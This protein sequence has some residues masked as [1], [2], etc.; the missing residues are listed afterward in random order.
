MAVAWGGNL[1][2]L[3][4]LMTACPLQL[5]LRCPFAGLRNTYLDSRN[6]FLGVLRG[7]TKILHWNCIFYGKISAKKNNRAI[8][9]G[10]GLNA[11]E[12]TLVLIMLRL[13]R[14][15]FRFRAQY[16]NGFQK[17]L[18]NAIHVIMK[19]TAGGI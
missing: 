3:E 13:M 15:N 5:Y 4:T 17:L 12:V 2:C 7:K 16:M 9:V 10:Q 1:L 8:N 19:S 18:L 14:L 11:P 6:N